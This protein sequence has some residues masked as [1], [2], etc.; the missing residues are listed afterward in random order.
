MRIFMFALIMSL[1]VSLP[2][3]GFELGGEYFLVK[4]KTITALHLGGSISPTVDI[5]ADIGFVN[6]DRD[7]TAQG[8]TGSFLGSI[9]G[10]HFLH[11]RSIGD[12]LQLRLGGGL[13]YWPLYGIHSEESMLGLAF[14]SELRGRIAPQAQFFLRSRYYVLK[15]DG[16]QPGVDRAGNESAPLVWSTGL[17]WSFK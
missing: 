14:V 8:A 16:L 3:S 9:L 12:G 15:S 6:S 2:A 4:D 1:S 10:L 11:R 13:D 5:S 17:V 7:E